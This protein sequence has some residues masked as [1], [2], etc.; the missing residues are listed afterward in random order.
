MFVNIKA[1]NGDNQL[2]YEVNPYDYSAGTLKGLS[3]NYRPGVPA[4]PSPLGLNE[5]YVDK[6]V[7]EAHPSSTLTGEDGQTFHFALAT[8]RYKDNRIPPKGFDID[9]AAARLAQPRWDGA[10][11]PDYFTTAEYAGGYDDFTIPD[12]AAI[13]FPSG[14]AYVE[15][16]LYY[17][18]TSREYIEF[19]RD[20]I[21]GNPDNR[22]L[23]AG[24]YV[25]Q[26]DPFFSQLK[27]WGDT[28]WSL[29][30]HNMNVDG[31]RPFLMAQAKIG[32]PPAPACE[33]AGTPQNLSATGGRRSVTLTW[34]AGSP[35]P[36]GGYNIYYD[37][38][39][40]VQFIAGVPAGTLNYKDN[41]LT[42]NAEYC[43]RVAAW[44]DCN[45]NGNYDAGIDT[46]SGTSNISCATTQ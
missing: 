8:D 45:A 9:N 43:Y 21:N 32:T 37:Q 7:Y 3:Y 39:G 18:T 44:N 33:T 41:R 42:R 2:I 38:A 11:A 34:E 40:K 36:T 1:Y 20:E 22:T 15:I 31:A 12:D 5:V 28:I 17:Q 16:N 46:E 26:S 19:L 30:T 35:T 25:V 27:A 23:P 13:P 14:A 29:W 4:P 6:L 24:A 10:D